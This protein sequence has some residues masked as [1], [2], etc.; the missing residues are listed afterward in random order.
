MQQVDAAPGGA[1]ELH[2]HVR[3]LAP[4]RPTQPPLITI[5]ACPPT[6]IQSGLHKQGIVDIDAN[7]AGNPLACAEYACDIFDHLH[8]I[9]VRRGAAPCAC[10]ASVCIS[11]GDQGAGC[12]T[13]FNGFLLYG[14]SHACSAAVAEF[15]RSPNLLRDLEK[16]TAYHPLHPVSTMLVH[17]PACTSMRTS[18]DTP[19]PPHALCT[20]PTPNPPLTHR[21]SAAPTPAIWRPSS[22]T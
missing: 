12:T 2:L 1:L 18:H 20:H 14:R 15:D 7:N 3:T 8:E 4:D 16:P 5:P 11:S 19:A 10:Y 17:A 22:K 13:T 9:E 6:G 21:G